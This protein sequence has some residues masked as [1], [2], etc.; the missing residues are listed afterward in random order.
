[1]KIRSQDKGKGVPITGHEGPWGMWIR[2]HIYIATAL[3]R[4][5]IARPTLGRF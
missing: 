1:M 2:A 3:G 5:R 4:G